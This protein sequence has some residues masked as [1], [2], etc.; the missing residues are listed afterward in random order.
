MG[1]T[2]SWQYLP[3]IAMAIAELQTAGEDPYHW[4]LFC[5]PQTWG[6]TACG[7]GGMGGAAV[8]TVPTVILRY[9]NRVRVYHDGRFVNEVKRTNDQVR[10]HMSNHDFPGATQKAAWEKMKS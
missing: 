8:T 10:I 4:E 2:S 7:F 9:A 1:H 6:S 5:W 3:T